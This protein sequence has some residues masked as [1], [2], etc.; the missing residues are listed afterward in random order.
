MSHR[1]LPAFP[2]F[3][4]PDHGPV[5][6]FMAAANPVLAR[7]NVLIYS[8]VALGGMMAWLVGH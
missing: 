8:G 7:A 2:G 5:L 4:A 6:R 1:A 3:C